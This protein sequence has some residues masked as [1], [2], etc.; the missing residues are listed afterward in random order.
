MAEPN[1]D[2]RFQKEEIVN[3]FDREALDPNCL[4]IED[5]MGTVMASPEGAKVL[6]AVMAKARAAR[7][8][9]AQSSSG[10]ANL[11]RMMGAM[12]VQS[13]LKQAGDTIGPEEIRALNEALQRIPR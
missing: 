6:G 1:P 13:I 12:K 8:D 11:Q 2:Y 9:V 7:G 10:N 5:T 3:W 4:S